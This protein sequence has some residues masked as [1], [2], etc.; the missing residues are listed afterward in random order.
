MPLAEH[1]LEVDDPCG[2]SM[3][4]RDRAPRLALAGLDR[5][6]D[7]RIAPATDTPLRFRAGLALLACAVL[8]ACEPSKPP[9]PPPPEVLVV[10]VAARDVPV[11]SE[12]LGTTEGFVDAAVRAQVSGYLIARD[13]QEGQ[14][15]RKGDLLF[16][17]DPRPFQ[18]ALDQ[19]Q[20]Q[21]A[22][23]RATL[24]RERLDV[25]RYTPLV[26]QGAVS[27]QEYDNAVQNARGAQASVQTA[28][29]AVEKAK[30][31]LGFTEIR[32]PVDGIVGVAQGQLGDFVGPGSAEPLT[33]VSQLD[34]IRVSFPLSEQE[35][36]HF[37]PRVQE[38][39]RVGHF[40]E[41][42]LELILADG[43]VYPHRG[44]GYPAGLGVD[45]RTGTITVKGRFP[46]P[47][48]LLR[49]GQYARVRVEIDVRKNA[50][51][52]PQRA[53]IDLQGK[54]QLAVVGPEDEVE[55]R[56]VE[57]GPIWKTLVVIEKGVAAGERVIVEGT[58]KVQPGLVV[59][60][61]LAP[62]DTALSPSADAGS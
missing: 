4:D 45:P 9:D 42:S 5:G 25:V 40:R 7:G 2:A 3:L 1:W 48:Y 19:A 6:E 15:V 29:A 11:I 28:Q 59:A 20:G 21:L 62:P 60:P 46:N 8:W 44:T 36:L 57:V 47:G 24:E 54:K 56:N 37:A 31:D 22:S 33:A 39:L 58:Q 41:G 26:K 16:R 53:L 51:T 61:K 35:Y 43:S 27:Q 23:A 50:L 52:V 10:E 38:A 18:A 30:I 12:W 32:S 49:P 13:Y 17:I 14:L 55:V 34:P